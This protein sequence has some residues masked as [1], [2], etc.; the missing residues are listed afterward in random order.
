MYQDHIDLVKTQATIRT[1]NFAIILCPTNKFH[2]LMRR[3]L[4]HHNH[5]EDY[6]NQ[7]TD[8]SFN[9]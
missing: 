1:I 6:I 5:A 8:L 9:R 4:N 7:Q 3:K 2:V